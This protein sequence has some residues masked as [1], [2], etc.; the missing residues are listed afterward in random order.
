KQ[1]SADLAHELR[2]P[3]HA[4]MGQTEVALSKPR[5]KDEYR[6]VLES[7]LEEQGRLARLIDNLLFLARA[8]NAQT[9]L[10]RD[11][12]D[13]AKELDGLIAYFDVMAQEN[14]VTLSREGG[15]VIFADR[16]FFNRAVSNL[17]SNALRHTP[18][19]GSIRLIVGSRAEGSVDV[20][21]VDNGTGIAPAQ[22][23]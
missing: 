7:N 13:V 14:D 16:S 11:R 2:T 15:G 8:D 3:M 1:F 12:I 5:S 9:A 17:I 20:Q 4:M 19:G 22:L 6:T 18:R 23:P 21:V 10:T